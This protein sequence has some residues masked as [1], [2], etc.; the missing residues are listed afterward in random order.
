MSGPLIL[1]Q[2]SEVI[3]H[4]SNPFQTFARHAADRR[5]VIFLLA[6]SAVILIPAPRMEAQVSTAVVLGTVQDS[7][8]GA[9]VSADVKLTS[10]TTG[11]SIDTVTGP[12]G[13][14]VF[15][16]VKVGRYTMD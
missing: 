7:S 6:V 4:S 9:I 11:I 14:Y 5:T 2:F 13:G 12:D 15:P 16:Q 1:A 8:G 10:E 3:M